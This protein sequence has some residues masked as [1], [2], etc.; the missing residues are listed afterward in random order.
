MPTRLLVSYNDIPIPAYTDILSMVII[1]LEILIIGTINEFNS[2][3]LLPLEACSYTGCAFSFWRMD[4]V[5]MVCM[6]W[7]STAWSYTPNIISGL[8]RIIAITVYPFGDWHWGLSCARDTQKEGRCVDVPTVL[9]VFFNYIFLPI[10]IT[11]K[12]ISYGK[13]Y[14][15]IGTIPLYPFRYKGLGC[16]DGCWIY[17]YKVGTNN[18]NGVV[19]MA[20]STWRQSILLLWGTILQFNK[21]FHRMHLLFK[22]STVVSVDL[23]KEK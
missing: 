5:N 17:R 2:K 21:P 6:H 23:V 14:Q 4:D 19:I 8:E 18:P 20:A 12:K 13:I 16:T 9:M 1:D 11:I 22:S 7:P 15:Y 10:P 3:I